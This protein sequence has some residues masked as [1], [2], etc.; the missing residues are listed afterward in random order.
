MLSP[1]ASDSVLHSRDSTLSSTKSSSSTIS[2]VASSGPTYSLHLNLSTTS[3]NGKS[4]L[5]KSRVVAGRGVGE[6]VDEEGGIEE[7]EVTR[8]LSGLLV[9]AGLVGAEEEGAKEE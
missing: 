6:F 7:G 4:L 8:W 3:N 1:S 5:H 2:S 9:D